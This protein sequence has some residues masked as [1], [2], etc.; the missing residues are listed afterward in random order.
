MR[1][2]LGRC[3]AQPAILTASRPLPH[4][5]TACRN[6]GDDGA[7]SGAGRALPGPLPKVGSGKFGTPWARM[8]RANDTIFARW[9]ADNCGGGPLGGRYPLHA[10]RAL[11]KAGPAKLIPSTT[12]PPSP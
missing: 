4:V 5:C 3:M 12:R 2:S 7:T 1:A 6:A 10:L 11:L 8:Q 9:D